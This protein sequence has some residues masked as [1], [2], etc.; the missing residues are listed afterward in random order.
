MIVQALVIPG[1]AR[2]LSGLMTKLIHPAEFNDWQNVN[3]EVDQS[4]QS[5]LMINAAMKTFP[6][7]LCTTS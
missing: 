3:T 5:H 6:Q 4:T 2:Y 7:T 1:N